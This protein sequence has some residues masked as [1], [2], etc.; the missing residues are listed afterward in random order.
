[1]VTW[2]KIFYRHARSTS[3][4]LVNQKDVYRAQKMSLLSK[5]K[6]FRAILIKVKV[7]R[8]L[9]TEIARVTLKR[10]NEVDLGVRDILFLVF[11]TSDVGNSLL[12]MGFQTPWSTIH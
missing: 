1:M 4:W 9:F 8:H 5:I 10:Q 12:L 6:V 7:K 11:S 2:L 3:F